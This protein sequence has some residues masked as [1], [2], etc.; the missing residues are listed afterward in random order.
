VPLDSPW[1]SDLSIFYCCMRELVLEQS[2]ES[3]G[4][5]AEASMELAPS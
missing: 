3:R 4:G 2:L 5:S 1:R